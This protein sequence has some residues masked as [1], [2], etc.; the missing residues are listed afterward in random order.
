[1]ALVR[2]SLLPLT[3]WPST[4]T[5][6]SPGPQSGRPAP[7]PARPPTVLTPWMATWLSLGTPDEGEQGP[8]EHEGHEEVHGRAGHRHQQAGVE[9]LLPVGAGLVLGVD[10]L[11]VGHARDLH[12]A[13]Q[14][15]GLDPVLGLAPSERPQARPE[16]EEVFG[17][18]HP[19]PLGRQQVAE[20]VD[21]DHDDDGGD[22]DEE[23][24][25]SG[26]HG[27]KRHCRGHQR[28]ARRRR[29]RGDLDCAGDPGGGPLPTVGDAGGGAGGGAQVVLTRPS[30]GRRRPRRR[31][32]GRRRPP[33]ARRRS[34]GRATPTGPATPVGG[35]S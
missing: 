9:G 14:R 5:I 10:L 19:A 29:R 31:P 27:H 18:L 23:V 11:E 6:T 4:E 1:M 13:P 16:P 24:D 3:A 20:L 26:G 25:P 21:H 12:V 28:P 8:Q 34:R 15:E 7:V 30:P 32:D 22:H 33:R 17:H 2:V 35:A